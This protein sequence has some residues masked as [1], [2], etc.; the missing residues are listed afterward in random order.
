MQE[1]NKSSIL[2]VSGV[3]DQT[4]DGGDTVRD[5]LHAD[6]AGQDIDEDSMEMT[7]LERALAID[8]IN[9]IV[10]SD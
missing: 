4:D 10:Q 6:L 9:E 1:E 8:K 5:Y 7:D 3:F 2:Q